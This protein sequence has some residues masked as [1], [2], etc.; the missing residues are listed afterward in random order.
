M[1]KLPL[2]ITTFAKIRDKKE[3]YLYVD[4]TD[5][6]LRLI[7]SGTY[8]FLS[9]PRRFGKSLFIDTLSDIFK[10]KK[11]LFEGL[12]VYDK[13]DWSES[14]PVI[15]IDFAKGKLVSLEDLKDKIQEILEENERALDVNCDSTA[16]ARKRFSNLIQNTYEKYNQKV[17]ILIDEYDKPI[18]D[19]ITN[20]DEAKDI[21]DKLGD[22]YSVIKG[23]DQ[24]IKF[25]FMTG[26]SKFSKMN[27]FSGLN[28]L[29]DITIDKK[30]ATIC[31]YTH[32]D[33]KTTFK[34]HLQDVD[35]DKLKEWY[36]GYNYFGD[37]VY[38]PFD[39]LLFISNSCEYKNYW[40]ETGNPRFLIDKLKESDYNIPQLENIVTNSETLNSFDIEK[41]DLVALLWQTGYLTFD[42]K[43]I[44]DDITEYKLKVP[45]K[46]IQIS[47]NT[48]FLNYLTDNSVDIMTNQRALRKFLKSDDLQNLKITISSLFASI[49]YN[50]YVKN[51]IAHYEGYYASVVFTY[52]VSLGFECI[53]EDT[54]N[55][56]RID[57]TI[58]LPNRIVIIEFKVDIKETALKQIKERKYY[59]KYQADTREIF[60]V[61]ICFSSED[62]NITE[63]EV[64][65]I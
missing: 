12:Y 61:G 39:I 38:N 42:K 9:R 32:N 18:L 44:E 55:K 30:Y 3:N 49:P 28:N 46:E 40:W 15:K 36:N 41:I 56:G 23:S 29:Q 19:N 65:K 60:I 54:T 50:N 58:K 52:L 63:F 11:E 26:V 14:Y 1:K 16:Y 27:L 5:I 37:A 17:V 57:L 22:F 35:L 34:E 8:Y 51:K 13:W 43:I 45:N 7:E 33:I 47:L 2:S 25:V 59:E 62:K 31:G 20:D 53:A 6:A 24:Y 21:R 4:K 48:L 10:A 64:E